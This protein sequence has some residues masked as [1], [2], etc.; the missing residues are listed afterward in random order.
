MDLV[1]ILSSIFALVGG[2]MLIAA[3]RQFNR[4]RA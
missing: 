4:R 3:G 1:S 2:V